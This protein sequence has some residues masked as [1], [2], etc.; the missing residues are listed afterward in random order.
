MKSENKKIEVILADRLT[1]LNID[2]NE[3][4]SALKKLELPEKVES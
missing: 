1:G 4:K 3:I 2:E